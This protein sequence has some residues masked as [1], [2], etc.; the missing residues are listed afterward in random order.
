MS[1]ILAVCQSRIKLPLEEILEDTRCKKNPYNFLRMHK[2]RFLL[3]LAYSLQIPTD[4]K[5]Y[6]FPPGLFSRL[7]KTFFFGKLYYTAFRLRNL[8]KLHVRLTT[9]QIGHFFFEN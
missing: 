2:I 8:D 1:T 5:Y 6:R 7:I 4:L 3:S 9:C